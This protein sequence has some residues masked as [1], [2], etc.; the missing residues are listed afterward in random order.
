MPIGHT[1]ILK[2]GDLNM[3]KKD[4]ETDYLEVLRGSS[5]TEIGKAFE[6]VIHI[7]VSFFSN[8]SDMVTAVKSGLE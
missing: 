6:S 3:E 5:G 8:F 7:D 4:C 2:F 1:I